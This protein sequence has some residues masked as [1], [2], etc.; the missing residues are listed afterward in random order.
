MEYGNPDL[1]TEKSYNY[2]LGIEQGLPLN[3]RV[4]LTGFR[5]DVKNYIEKLFNDVPY[6]N[7]DEY[8]FQGIELTAET[9]FMKN[10]MLR[11]RIYLSRHPGQ[12]PRGQRK[13][14]SNTG[15]NIN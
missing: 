2:E 1:E 4:S 3:S 6:E 5:S 14:N 13:T 7:N 12:V 11:A 10:L 9:Q 8:R 15:P